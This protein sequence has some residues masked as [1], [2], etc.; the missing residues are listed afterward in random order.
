MVRT[1]GPYAYFVL[2]WSQVFQTFACEDFPE[3]KSYLR[4]DFGVECDTD[5]HKAFEIYAGIM[6]CICEF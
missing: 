5:K 4:A 6:I 3:D 1:A 2:H